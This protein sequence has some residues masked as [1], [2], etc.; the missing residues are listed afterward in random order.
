MKM[1]YADL[2]KQGLIYCPREIEAG[3]S[4]LAK[5]GIEFLVQDRDFPEII[6]DVPNLAEFSCGI[7]CHIGAFEI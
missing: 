3:H 5:N 6:G 2:S 1:E 4:R 7:D